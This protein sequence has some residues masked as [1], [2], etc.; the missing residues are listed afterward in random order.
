MTSGQ[1]PRVPA[2]HPQGSGPAAQGIWGSA[3]AGRPV[4][5]NANG[6]LEV[7][8][9][10]GTWLFHLRRSLFCRVPVGTRREFLPADAWRPYDR[11]SLSPEG[12]VR[13]IL[14]RDAHSGITGWLHGPGC[15]RCASL[16][17]ELSGAGAS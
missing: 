6:T 15:S 8:T 16:Q 1:L 3:G 10:T 11:L 17:V 4:T 13:V 2:Q 7:E 14:D 12:V 5:V 9:C